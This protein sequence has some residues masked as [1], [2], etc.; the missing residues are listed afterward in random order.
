MCWSR[1]LISSVIPDF[2]SAIVSMNVFSLPVIA[3]F[4]RED[5]KKGGFILKSDIKLFS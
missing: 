3:F 2:S 1:A 4:I 5:L